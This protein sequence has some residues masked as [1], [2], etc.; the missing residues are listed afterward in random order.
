MGKDDKM[1]DD[2]TIIDA[3]KT[4]GLVLLLLFLPFSVLGAGGEATQD[5]RDKPASTG[6]DQND[7]SLSPLLAYQ[8]MGRYLSYITLGPTFSYGLET[9]E[10]AL[11]ATVFMGKVLPNKD[12]LALGSQYNL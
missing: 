8:P 6:I 12:V 4:G 7:V 11:S 2:R 10:D 9:E 1:E 3:K 5:T